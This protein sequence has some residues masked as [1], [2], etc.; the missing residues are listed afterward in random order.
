MLN[1]NRIEFLDVGQTL[2]QL[3]YISPANIVSLVYPPKLRTQDGS[4]HFA[5]RIR[6]IAALVRDLRALNHTLLATEDR[7]TAAFMESF[8]QEITAGHG[9]AEAM[10]RT[11]L[12]FLRSDRPTRRRVNRW[13]P[14]QILGNP[15]AG[16]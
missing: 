7:A 14:F 8:Y 13:A 10:R 2:Q 5:Q 11:Q 3:Q 4:L 9:P 16:A 15:A 12:A 1:I 6:L